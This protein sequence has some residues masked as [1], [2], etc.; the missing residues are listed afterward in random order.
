MTSLDY[1]QACHLVGAPVG[2]SGAW[3]SGGRAR[4]VPLPAPLTTSF[5]QTRSG[6]INQCRRTLRWYRLG[7][8]FKQQLGRSLHKARAPVRG[9]P[10]QTLSFLF[11]NIHSQRDSSQWCTPGRHGVVLRQSRRAAPS[12]KHFASPWPRSVRRSL[13]GWAGPTF[14][15]ISEN[16]T[17]SAARGIRRMHT[18]IVSND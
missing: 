6:N 12:H 16:I 1:S 13:V 14:H 4:A 10:G 8:P 2:R 7:P 18:K 9:H 5:N 15:G 11:S 17:S 3:H